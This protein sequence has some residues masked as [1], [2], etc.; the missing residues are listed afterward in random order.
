[1]FGHHLS[2]NQHFVDRYCSSSRTERGLTEKGERKRGG[3][4]KVREQRKKVERKLVEEGEVSSTPFLILSTFVGSL[5]N[6]SN[7]L[8]FFVHL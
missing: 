7:S 6:I 8:S 2:K 4:E 1:M 3:S 5:S